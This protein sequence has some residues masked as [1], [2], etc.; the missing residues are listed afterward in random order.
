V[1]G[2]GRGRGPGVRSP[3]PGE[4]GGEVS[5]AR[6][7]DQDFDQIMERHPTASEFDAL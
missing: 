1:I 2:C 3:A 4:L 6:D 7:F 5:Q